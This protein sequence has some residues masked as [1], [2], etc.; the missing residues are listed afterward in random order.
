MCWGGGGVI[1]DLAPG[2]EAEVVGKG[3]LTM[4]CVVFLYMQEAGRRVDEVCL[5]QRRRGAWR[6]L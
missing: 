6:I 1:S 3:T 5:P 4:M 2:S